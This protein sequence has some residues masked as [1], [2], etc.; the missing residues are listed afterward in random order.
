MKIKN[1][2][3]KLLHPLRGCLWKPGV[4]GLGVRRFHD[5]PYRFRFNS[6]AIEHDR[7]YD[8]GGQPIMRFY[9]DKLFLEQCLYQCENYFQCFIAIIYFFFVVILGW[10]FFRYD[11]KIE[12]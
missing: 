8:A 5:L 2:I 11:R 6:A 10:A 7:R 3:S 1:I 4:N 9:A 12:E